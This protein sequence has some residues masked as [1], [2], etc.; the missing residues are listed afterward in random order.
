MF[1]FGRQIGGI[2]A[3]ND[4]ALEETVPSFQEALLRSGLHLKILQFDSRRQYVVCSYGR[5]V[6]RVIASIQLS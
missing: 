6:T 4:L 2:D 5:E 1:P 3:K